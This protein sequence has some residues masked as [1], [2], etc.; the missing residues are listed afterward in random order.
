MPCSVDVTAG[1]HHSATALSGRNKT[2]EVNTPGFGARFTR[3]I[4]MCVIP[5]TN[6]R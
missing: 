3:A 6:V 1:A 5:L 2:T 4:K